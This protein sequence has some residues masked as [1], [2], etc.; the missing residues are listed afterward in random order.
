M[1]LT[2][3][4]SDTKMIWT[5]SAG[6]TFTL[7]VRTN[8]NTESPSTLVV[9]AYGEEVKKGP[10]ASHAAIAKGQT[11]VAVFITA[12]LENTRIELWEVAG[13]DA[14]LLTYSYYKPAKPY[15]AIQIN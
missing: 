3:K 6:K 2:L 11:A 12:A 7:E 15:M 13:E 10:R 4:W 9:S 1:A 8:K 5:A 14:Q